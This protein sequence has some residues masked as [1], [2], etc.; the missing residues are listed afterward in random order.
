MELIDRYIYAVTQRL[1]EPQREDIKRE[2][3]GLIEDMM[4]ERASEG[5]ETREDAKGVLMELGDPNA[6]AAKYRGFNERFLIGPSMFDSYLTTLKIVLF[7]I[8]IGLTALFAI[9]I[10][11]K[12]G[13]VPERF[14][15]FI[16]SLFTASAQGFGW[17]T[18]IFA[19][20]EYRKRMNASSSADMSKGWDPENLPQIPDQQAR[21]KLSEPITGIIFTVLIAVI[22]IY[23]VELLGVWRL[24]EGERVVISFLDADAFRAYL[25][26]VW[27]LAALG[28]FKECIRIIARNRSGTLL[29]FHIVATVASTVAACII[30][31]DS[32]I[33]NPDFIRELE[34]TGLF[35]SEGKNYD[36]FVS[37]WA[38]INE[39][40]VGVIALFGVIDILSETYKWYRV[41]T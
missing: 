7:S 11:V 20:I 14:T 5:G 38:R 30:L 37:V 27:A 16:V 1:P 29:V 32:A 6:L 23:S 4:D 15:E 41:K 36:S 13:D 26:V 2:L 39:W 22:C 28:I 25:P 10:I 34:A 18:V 35:T 3:R 24:R 19:W 21:I 17:V 31:A 12:P 33:W 8:L 40:F 9:E